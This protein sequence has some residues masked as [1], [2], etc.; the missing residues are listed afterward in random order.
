VSYEG[1]ERR[2]ATLTE[3]R[4]K[5]MIEKAVQQAL[6]A[7][8]QHLVAHMDKQF[9]AL[10]ASFADAFP[11]GDPHGHRIAHQKFIA[12][13]GWWERVKGEAV[14]KATAATLWAFIVFL[15]IAAWEYVR[16]ETKK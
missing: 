6:A 3:D 12:N 9:A 8:E 1:P 16:Q 5:L 11:D 7:H 10:K 13:A 15:A 14:G 2:S 4:V